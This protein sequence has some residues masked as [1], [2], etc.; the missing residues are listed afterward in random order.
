MYLSELK[1]W[2]FRKY[3]EGEKKSPIGEEKNPGLHLRLNSGLNLLVGEN[4]SG[5][6]A[7]I[8]AIKMVLFTQSYEYYR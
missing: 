1:I 5:K 8:D 4:D 7:I 6:T 2:N 3:G